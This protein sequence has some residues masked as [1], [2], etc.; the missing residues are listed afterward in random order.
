MRTFLARRW[1]LLVLLAGLALAAG[2]PDWLRPVVGLLDPRWVVGTALFFMAWGLESRSLLGALLRPLPAVWAGLLSYGLVP[3]LAWLAGRLQSDA[4]L[5]LGLV[6]IASVPCT[7][8]SAVLWTR[9]AGGS[10][11]TAL[12]TVLFTTCTSWLITTA[13]LT[14]LTGSDVVLDAVDMM[15]G[16]ALVLLLPV[17]LGQLGRAPAALARLAT[18]C[19]P[20]TGVVSRFLILSIILKAAVDVRER[21]G[22][23]P[24]AL[25]AG[26]LLLAAGLC[27]GTHLI[28]LF[29]GL[30]SSRG[31]RFDRPCQ[32][33]VA[34][35]CSQKTLPVSLYLFDRYFKEAHPLAVVPLV[36][37]HV[38]QLVVDTLLADWLARR[39]PAEAPAPG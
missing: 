23:R 7:L 13:L 34:F 33:A 14:F 26:A 36:F 18:R 12:L 35:A 19:K 32:I 21:L 2:R 10:E 24:A 38:G 17:S 29:G 25:S 30:W 28:A 9:M 22:E 20:V 31:L 11:A 8:A 27:L 5:A 15:R 4:D 37:Y 16:L 39:P 1:F 6:T 3:T